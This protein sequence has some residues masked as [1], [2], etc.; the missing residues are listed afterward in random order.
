[1]NLIEVFVQKKLIYKVSGVCGGYL[2]VV[3]VISEESCM[4]LGGGS[5]QTIRESSIGVVLSAG[6]LSPSTF[7]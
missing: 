4:L 6:A 7:L 5:V 3:W 1:M 2:E